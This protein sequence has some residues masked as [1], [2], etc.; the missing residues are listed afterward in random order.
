MV[1]KG[2]QYDMSLSLST[3]DSTKCICFGEH[4]AKYLSTTSWRG[5][6]INSWHHVGSGPRST[7]QHRKADNITK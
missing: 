3:R 2:T 1:L 4:K 7:Y 6:K 5:E